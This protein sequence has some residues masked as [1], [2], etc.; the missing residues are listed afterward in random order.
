MVFCAMRFSTAG[1]PE[2]KHHMT[3]ESVTSTLEERGIVWQG[4][5]FPTVDAISVPLLWIYSET[6][7]W[8]IGFYRLVVTQLSWAFVVAI[9]LVIERTRKMFETKTEIRRVAREKA[10][11][12]ARVKGREEGERLAAEHMRSELRAEGVQLSPEAEARIFNGDNSR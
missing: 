8:G 7:H 10:I 2:A 11:E 6:D 3:L 1:K 5:G 4:V 9:A 12:E